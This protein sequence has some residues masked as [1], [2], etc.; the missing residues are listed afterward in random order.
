M[1]ASAIAFNVSKYQSNARVYYH[2]KGTQRGGQSTETQPIA[3]SVMH[4]PMKYI[5][6]AVVP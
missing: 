5:V 2:S 3:H 1:Y 6:S 4:P